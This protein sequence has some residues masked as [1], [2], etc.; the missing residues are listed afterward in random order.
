MISNAFL[1]LYLG[2]VLREGRA[3]LFLRPRRH[4]QMLYP[5]LHIQHTQ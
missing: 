2:C 1:S 5:R 4:D 3:Y